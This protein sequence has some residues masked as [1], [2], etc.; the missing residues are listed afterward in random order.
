MSRYA[1]H[2]QRVREITA[3]IQAHGPAMHRT[4]A[5]AFHQR[6]ALEWLGLWI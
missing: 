4:R 6:R 2:Q 3:L 1:Y 5:C